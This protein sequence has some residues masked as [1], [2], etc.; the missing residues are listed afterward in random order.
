MTHEQ[1]P[2]WRRAADAVPTHWIIVAVV[3]LLVAASAAFGGLKDAPAQALDAL[4][5]GQTHH[6]LRLDVAVTRAVLIDGFPGTDIATDDGKRL[7]VV[8]AHVRNHW[9]SPVRPLALAR[10]ADTI[11]VRGVPGVKNGSA[12]D[13]VAVLSD[14]AP[15]P[16]L[17]PG[18]PVDLTFIWN[19]EPSAL[20]AGDDLHLQLWDEDQHVNGDLLTGENFEQPH[21]VGS[22]TVPVTDVGAGSDG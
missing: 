1:K 4:K 10:H 2:R 16:D 13:Y 8:V 18:V 9:H 19:V 7:L 15:S 3:A 22:V 12:P 14:A 21:L 17:Q 11:G 20:A 6:G 5:P